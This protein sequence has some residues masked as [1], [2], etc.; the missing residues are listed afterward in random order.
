MAKKR[1]AFANLLL[2]SSVLFFI[3]ITVTAIKLNIN[4][5]NYFNYV[6]M[7]TK[8]IDSNM[9]MDCSSFWETINYDMLTGKEILQY[10]MWT[11]YSSCRLKNDFGGQM[12][13]NPPGFDGQ[14]A[15]CIDKKTAPQPT[16][17]IVYS[18]GISNEWSFDEAMEQYGCEVF[19]FD[20]S[21]DMEPQ[22]YHPRIH[23]YNWGLSYEDANSGEFGNWHMRS[24]SSIYNNLTAQHGHVVI[25]YLK[26]D[27]EH[28]EWDVLPN[29][30]YSGML[31]KV[32][33][34][35]IEIHLDPNEHIKTY[36]K[37][38]NILRSLEQMG[39]VRFDSKYNQWNPAK[40][41][42]LN[43]SGYLA[44]EIAWYN[45]NLTAA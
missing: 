16:K 4:N 18:F 45:N 23:F 12:A 43:I 2:I 10:F 38:V 5:T 30:I 37:K 1:S 28:S 32:R 29:I 34:L 25:D 26:M 3:Y 9:N 40:F 21:M 27:I 6:K 35:G 14:K 22:D 31:S 19:A 44:Y 42:E 13:K 17:C 8:L 33:Q 39:M 36:R 24:L 20:P 7:F 11:N 41:T 15:V